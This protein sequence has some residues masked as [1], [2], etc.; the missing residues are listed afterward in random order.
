LEYNYITTFKAHLF[1]GI[2]M[3][4]KTLTGR[5][6]QKISLGQLLQNSAEQYGSNPF[7][8][9]AETGE[10]LTYVEFNQLTNHIAHGL[11]SLGVGDKEYVAIML[12][13]CVQFLASSYALKKIGAIEVAINNNTRGPSLTR[14]INMTK[15]R[16]LITA[17]EYLQQLSEV[18]E[19]L[20]Y[21]E[22][23]IMMDDHH[24]ASKLFPNLEVLPWQSILGE[25]DSNF[26][27]EFS[28][29][30]IAVILF[31]SGTTGVSKGC[32]IPH[33]SSV[34]AAESMIEA[35]N[36][37]EQDCVYTPYPLYHVGATQYDILPAMMV[38]GQ[39]IIRQGFSLSHFWS[40]IC[41]YKATWF[42]SLGS[43]QQLLWTAEPCIEEV[44][45][46]L[47]FIW[48]TPLPVN[49]D[50]FEERFHLKLVRGTGYGSTEAGGVALPL[51]DKSGAGKVLDR[52]KVA[53]V[54]GDDNE[55]SAGESGELVIRPLEPSIMASKYIGMPEETAKA[56]RN[57]W[58]YTGDLARLD[59]EGD[60][61][62]LA[63][64]SERIRVKGEMVSAYEIE[65]GIF[66]HPSVTDCAVIGISDGTG[67]EQVKAFVPLKEQKTLALEELRLFCAPIMSHFMVP[68]VLKVIKEMPR[69]QTG[70]PAKAELQ[71]IQ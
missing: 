14:M 2:P 19:G 35:F 12:P 69:T 70:K 57:S 5:E 13:N 56:W 33:R 9:Q 3:K 53:I 21:I 51:F 50:D 42:M 16:I 52:Y 24:F 44:Q 26:L 7:V 23:V 59:E 41:R 20:D 22:R 48:G 30:E 27:C 49:H 65:E 61:F 39:A 58:F 45:H 25:S 29:E 6:N 38:G 47:R 54:D 68:T 10:C 15:C 40:D 55:L 28:D 46:N 32:D 64:M 60:L 36:L 62:W 8:T 34:R 11:I 67:E 4:K 63:R 71:K 37:N 31:T 66:T 43:V 17:G 1:G 18:V